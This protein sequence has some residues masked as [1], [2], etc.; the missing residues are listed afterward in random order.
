MAGL[1][2]YGKAES[3]R[4]LRA[5]DLN[6]LSSDVAAG[7]RLDGFSAGF[8]STPSP[9]GT[10]LRPSMPSPFLAVIGSDHGSS[11]AT[12]SSDSISV[13]QPSAYSWQEARWVVK[14]MSSSSG[15]RNPDYAIELVEGGLRG[16][17]DVLPAMELNGNTAVPVGS[18][19]RLYPGFGAPDFY[20]FSWGGG[21]SGLSAC[22]SVDCNAGTIT[23]VPCGGSSSGS[24]SSSSG[25]IS[26]SSS[27][28]DVIVTKDGSGGTSSST[29]SETL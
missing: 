13:D 25:K 15:N 7:T 27:S 8:V 3:G 9:F 19:V 22:F 5:S 17:F 21:G 12:S 1:P 26:S 4:Q 24:T 20:Y 10:Y 16:T 6:K 29:A 11:G 14:D 2:S 18:V 28:S 23:V